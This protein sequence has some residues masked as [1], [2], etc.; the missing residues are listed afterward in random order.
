MSQRGYAEMYRET[1]DMRSWACA[2]ETQERFFEQY[3]LMILN[4][5]SKL[6]RMGVRETFEDLVQTGA[7]ALLLAKEKYA[8]MIT[9]AE[10]GKRKKI[11]FTTYA[12]STIKGMMLNKNTRDDTVSLDEPRD[13]D[14]DPVN[15]YDLIPSQ[16]PGIDRVLER[17]ELWQEICKVVT[18]LP[19]KQRLVIYLRF[20]EGLTLEEIGRRVNLTRERVRQIEASALTKLRRRLAAVPHFKAA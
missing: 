11:H 2:E 19:P 12:Y 18:G 4:L 7:E 13:D 1:K 10:G 5:A 20:H 16:D 9:E 15:L 6:V 14:G 17:Q 3:R 8:I